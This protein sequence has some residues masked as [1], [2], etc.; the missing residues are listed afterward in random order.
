MHNCYPFSL[1]PLPYACNGLAPCLNR[2]TVCNHYE[3]HHRNYVNNLNQALLRYPA[4][5]SWTLEQLLTDGECLP[6]EI[7]IKVLRNAGGVYN[8][9]LYWNSMTP[10]SSGCPMGTLGRAIHEQYQSFALFQQQFQTSAAA[11]FGSGW[12]WLAVDGDDTLQ[13]CH[14]ANQDVLDLQQ[15]QPLLVLDLWEHAYYLQY[16]YNRERY[17]ENWWHLVNRQF[18]E[19]QYQNRSA[20]I[21]RTENLD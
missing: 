4:Y 1:Q 16:R 6:E 18:A 11:V 13:I 15:F 7:R 14:T 10:R 5:Q 21:Y 12:L 9:N 2:E 19:N 3:H 20:A 8:H 17:T